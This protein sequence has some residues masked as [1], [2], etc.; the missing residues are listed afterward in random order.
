M[1]IKEF[2]L[3]LEEFRDI[4]TYQSSSGKTKHTTRILDDPKSPRTHSSSIILNQKLKKEELTSW[5]DNTFKD[6]SIIRELKRYIK[7]GIAKKDDL[8]KYAVTLTNQLFLQNELRKRGKLDCEYC[9]KKL[10]LYKFDINKETTERFV[11]K[12]ALTR[13]NRNK[14]ATCDHKQPRSLGGDYFDENNLAVSCYQCNR[15]K[16][17]MSW[18]EWVELMNSPRWK[19]FRYSWKK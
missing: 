19:K 12:R 16:N 15:K 4:I 13:F 7:I 14:V 17:D 5:I 11:K 3:F 6:K 8:L 18:E 9:N 10:Q 2:K 1:I